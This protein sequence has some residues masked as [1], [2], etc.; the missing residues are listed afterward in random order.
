MLCGVRYAA[1]GS[2]FLF[3]FPK[4]GLGPDYYGVSWTQPETYP[5][6]RRQDMTLKRPTYDESI[7]RPAR[8]GARN[9]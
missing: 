3:P 9:G 2:R 7:R 8:E 5:S 6:S 1:E 4:V